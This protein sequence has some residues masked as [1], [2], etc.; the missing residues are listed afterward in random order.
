MARCLAGRLA[1]RRA[2]ALAPG[3]AH[4]THATGAAHAARTG[5]GARRRRLE[6]SD[7]ERRRGARRARERLPLLALARAAARGAVVGDGGVGVVD[8]CHHAAEAL[9]GATALRLE[10]AKPVAE[11]L[12]TRARLS[13]APHRTRQRHQ[14]VAKQQPDPQH[15]VAVDQRRRDDL[16]RAERETKPDKQ[17]ERDGQCEREHASVEQQ[18]RS[19]GGTH[20]LAS[21]ELARRELGA[22]RLGGE[23]SDHERHPVYQPP[24]VRRH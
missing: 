6:V 7:S 8:L 4:A 20:P 23:P 22:Q 12:Q 1:P 3:A 5:P 24:Y 15:A 17:V 11:L 10:D 19:C 21:R 2:R 18:I 13:L 16:Q 14:P 9:C